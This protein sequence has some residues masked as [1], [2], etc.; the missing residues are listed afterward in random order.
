MCNQLHNVGVL[1]CE[2]S[3]CIMFTAI[4]NEFAI[5]WLNSCSITI[6]L[7]GKSTMYCIA[8][9][10]HVVLLKEVQAFKSNYIINTSRN[11]RRYYEIS[12]RRCK[13]IGLYYYIIL[14]FK[15]HKICFDYRYNR[16]DLVDILSWYWYNNNCIH[17]V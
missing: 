5:I 2:C 15:S 6:Y 10:V 13:D 11:K 4:K 17:T 14:I 9:M 7:K 12:T 3:N 1:V 16:K 8:Y